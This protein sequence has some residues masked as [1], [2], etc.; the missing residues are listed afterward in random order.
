MKTFTLAIFALSLALPVGAYAQTAARLTDAELV[1]LATTNK[2][3][4][5]LTVESASYKNAIENVVSVLCRDATGF[6]PVVAGLGLGGAA[7]GLGIAALAVGAGT[8]T[9]DTQ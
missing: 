4:G 3:C 9:S 1:E 8:G 2:V 5:D 7:A 6:V